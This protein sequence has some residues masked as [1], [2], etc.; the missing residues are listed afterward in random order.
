[1]RATFDRLRGVEHAVVFMD[2]VVEIASR[3]QEH[4]AGQ[5][6]TNELLK[7]IPGFRAMS[8]RLLI[9][10]TNNINRLDPVLVRSGRFE[11]LIPIGPPDLNSCLE[12]GPALGAVAG[13]PA[14]GALARHAHGPGHVR[15][16]HPR[17]DAL[18]EQ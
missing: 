10:A 11:Y 2:E 4:N 18:D 7:A 16:G 9:C 14:V 5:A 13:N 17:L 3:R 1:M 8:G 6:I 12:A 15:H